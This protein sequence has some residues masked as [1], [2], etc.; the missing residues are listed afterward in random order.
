MSDLTFR[1]IPECPLCLKKM[2]EVLTK[3]GA[4]WVCTFPRCMI[5]INAADP[6]V[7]KWRDKETTFPDCTRCGTKMRMFFRTLDRAWKCYCPKCHTAIG[8]ESI[9][10]NKN[11]EVEA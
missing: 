5:S 3:R 10:P 4:F 2:R 7:G 11:W 8:T 1:H 9:M 6:A